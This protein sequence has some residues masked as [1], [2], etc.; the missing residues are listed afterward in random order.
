MLCIS[1]DSSLNK[2]H[3]SINFARD[4][5]ISLKL[6]N[7]EAQVQTQHSLCEIFV[8]QRSIGAGRLLSV[9]PLLPIIHQCFNCSV[10]MCVLR[11]ITKICKN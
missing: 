6:P 4:R 3:E 8:D 7:A 5:T 9:R 1:H 11:Y 2:T 10:A